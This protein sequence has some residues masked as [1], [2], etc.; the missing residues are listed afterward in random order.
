MPDDLEA[1]RIVVGHEV[2]MVAVN[3]ESGGVI[4]DVNDLAPRCG[5]AVNVRKFGGIQCDLVLDAMRV[6]RDGV[7]RTN[8]QANKWKI[9]LADRN[10]GR[11]AIAEY[12]S[13]FVRVVAQVMEI[14]SAVQ[15]VGSTG[16][17]RTELVQAVVEK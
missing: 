9:A 1:R 11:E 12:G 5:G 7:L 6:D 14:G 4:G 8:W 10:R 16:L 3:I 13:I 2:K 15:I 17:V